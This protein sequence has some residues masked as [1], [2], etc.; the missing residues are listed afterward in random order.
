ML[1]YFVC[2]LGCKYVLIK[3]FLISLKRDQYYTY[4]TFT[5][6]SCE[7]RFFCIDYLFISQVCRLSLLLSTDYCILKYLFIL[8]SFVHDFRILSRVCG[9]PQ[10]SCC[11]FLM[12]LLNVSPNK[13]ST[14]CSLQKHSHLSLYTFEQLVFRN[15]EYSLLLPNFASFTIHNIDIGTLQ[16]IN[17]PAG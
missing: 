6:K 10:Y 4:S 12:R 2:S 11:L 7:F 1:R 16:D 15:A 17:Q 9:I 13:M 8:V 14:I 3:I 5:Q